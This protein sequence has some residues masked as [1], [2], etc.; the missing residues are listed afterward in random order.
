MDN[1]QFIE[2]EERSQEKLF[3]VLYELIKDGKRIVL[4]A[5]KPPESIMVLSERFT[6][7]LELGAVVKLN[8]PDIDVKKELLIQFS[9]NEDLILSDE[10]IDYIAR[11]HY[12]GIRELKGIFNKIR[13]FAKLSGQTISVNMINLLKQD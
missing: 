4:A 7:F 5:N 12:T 9:E 3:K 10:V 2:G 11:D 13:S 8:N 6:S 1:L